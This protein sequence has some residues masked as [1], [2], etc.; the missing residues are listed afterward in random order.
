MGF[1]IDVICINQREQVPVEVV[2]KHI[3]EL[4]PVI[5]DLGK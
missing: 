1:N 4:L 3:N 2:L 5:H